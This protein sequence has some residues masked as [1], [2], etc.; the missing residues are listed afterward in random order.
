[1]HITLPP[2]KASFYSIM[3][4]ETIN[5][6]NSLAAIK[7]LGLIQIHIFLQIQLGFDPIPQLRKM[8]GPKFIWQAEKP[9]NVDSLLQIIKTR[10]HVFMCQHSDAWKPHDS[11]ISLTLSRLHRFKKRYYYLVDG[12]RFPKSFNQEAGIEPISLKF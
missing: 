8:C 11:V 5:T 7:L 12:N 10:D 1:M 9:N 2:T 3:S 6:S 4:D